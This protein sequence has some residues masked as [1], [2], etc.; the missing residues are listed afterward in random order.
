MHVFIFAV[1]RNIDVVYSFI[2]KKK[3]EEDE[4]KKGTGKERLSEGWMEKLDREF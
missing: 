4:E 3:N 1:D 2:L